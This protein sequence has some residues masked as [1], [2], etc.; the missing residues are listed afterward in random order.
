M[1][2]SVSRVGTDTL[3]AS[4]LWRRL[5]SLVLDQHD[6]RSE[7]SAALGLSF[8]RVKALLQIARSAESNS[9]T[10]MRELAELLNTDR[11]YLTLVIDD[12]ERRG[13]VRR[14]EHPVDRR[15][16]VVTITESGAAAAVTADSI[17]SRPPPSLIRLDQPDI[18]E[19]DRILQC[20]ERAPGA[21]EGS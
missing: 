16:K 2:P 4:G 6:R 14:Q 10:T 20:L 1:K 9:P 12:L 17:L 3:D 5:R 13:L 11:P 18:A 15:Q 19:L 7:V 8:I 21:A